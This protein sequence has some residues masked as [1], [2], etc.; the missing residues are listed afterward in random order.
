MRHFLLA[1]AAIVAVATGSLAINS[2]VEAAPI[3]AV[4]ADAMTNV[5]KTQFLFGGHR[6][7]WY[8]DGWH[9]PGWYWCGYRARVG[10]GY[11]GPEGWQGWRRDEHRDFRERRHY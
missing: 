2:R 3:G 10:F 4:A 11:G 7:C 8:V 6:H 5:E 9:G 1:G